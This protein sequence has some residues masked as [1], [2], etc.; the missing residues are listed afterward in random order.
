MIALRAVCPQCNEDIG[1]TDGGDSPEV[2]TNTITPDAVL[3]AFCCHVCRARWE[4]R[5]SYK[6]LPDDWHEEGT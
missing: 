3:A 6:P 1:L 2:A 5:T 4:I